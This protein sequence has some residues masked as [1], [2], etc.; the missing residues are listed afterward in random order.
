MIKTRTNGSEYY[1]FLNEVQV[2]SNDLYSIQ[3]ERINIIFN[4][5]DLNAYKRK[6]NSLIESYNKGLKK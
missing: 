4:N 6:L 1:M 2:V 5:F 3:R